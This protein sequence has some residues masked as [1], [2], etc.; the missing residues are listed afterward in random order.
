MKRIISLLGLLG[1]VVMVGVG[2][3]WTFGG[4]VD[5]W[6]KRW[7][8]VNFSGVYRGVGGGVLV[9]DFTVTPGTP[10]ATN[11]VSNE[12]IAR[13]NGVSSIFSGVLNRI[14]VVPGS[15]TITEAAITLVDDGAEGLSG[16]GATGTIDYGTGAWSIDLG[17]SPSDG[18]AIRASYS[19]TVAGAEGTG[20]AGPGTTRVTINSFTVHQEGETLQVTDNNGAVFKGKMGS[21]RGSGGYDGHGTPSVGETIIAQY[22]VKGVSASGLNVEIVG[23]FQ[24]MIGDA[25]V[26]QYFLT[27]RR[28]Y[29]TWIEVGGRT[30]DV[31]GQAA[32]LTVSGPV[33]SPDTD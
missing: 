32:P 22:S 23:T 14:P 1:M 30:G 33:D 16:S 27:S 3:D 24:A 15:V 11:A 9:T 31:N 5:S 2:C 17:Y 21:I 20:G 10:G 6:N 25:D 12:V 13:G 19:Y 28:M 4:G 8:W 26:G 7:N 29:G 18:N